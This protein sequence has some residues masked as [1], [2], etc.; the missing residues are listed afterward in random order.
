MKMKLM[1]RKYEPERWIR[2]QKQK[3][4]VAWTTGAYNDLY[5]WKYEHIQMFHMV[6]IDIDSECL[7]KLWKHPLFIGVRFMAIYLVTHRITEK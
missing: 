4:L 7:W 5:D 1:Q 6:R 2:E 3:S